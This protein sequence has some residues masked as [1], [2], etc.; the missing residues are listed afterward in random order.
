MSLVR[1]DYPNTTHEQILGPSTVTVILHGSE[2]Q[3]VKSASIALCEEYRNAFIKFSGHTKKID[4]YRM[5]L[6]FSRC[7]LK[8]EYHYDPE[9]L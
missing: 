3:T 5:E 8:D 1:H 4:G 6:T 2:F 7:L 9:P